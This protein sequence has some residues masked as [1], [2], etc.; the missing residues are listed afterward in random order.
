MA[1]REQLYSQAVYSSPHAHHGLPA[2]D[3][4]PDSGGLVVARFMGA[5]VP[6]PLPEG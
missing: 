3:R 6:V 5:P 4:K 1:M 2:A